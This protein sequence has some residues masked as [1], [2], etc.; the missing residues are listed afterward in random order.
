M[1]PKNG[2]LSAAYNASGK[3]IL[4][5]GA[6]GNWGGHFSVGMP[7]A[8]GCDA[9]LADYTSYK[10]ELDE[11]C[12]DIQTAGMPVKVE[13][14]FLEEGD[15][16]GG[17][18]LYQR[19]E[20]KYGKF[21]CI[22]DVCGI[23]TVRAFPGSAEV[24][25]KPVMEISDM[26]PRYQMGAKDILSGK[27]ILIL[28]AAGNWGSH[29]AMGMALA[30]RADLVLV[31]MAINKEKIAALREQIGDAVNISEEYVDAEQLMDRYALIE[32]MVQ[33]YEAFDAVMDLVNIN[34]D[35]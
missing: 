32:Q 31:D 22:L 23:D 10:E 6:G 21:S 28:G 35:M 13:R 9:V 29:M 12:Q 26:K 8:C 2:R 17:A 11:V 20:E 3:K 24:K 5:V 1:E 4:I 16:A 7:A 19:L 15:L 30:G 18:E 25:Q 33:K 34:A 14:C 27:T